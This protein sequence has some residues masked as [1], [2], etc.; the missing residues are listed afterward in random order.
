MIT[1]AIALGLLAGICVAGFQEGAVRKQV[2]YAA[3]PLVA[4]WSLMTF[5]HLTYGFVVLLPVMMLLALND[6]PRSTLR[7]AL[8][9]ILQIG[10]MFD[11][12]GLSRLM[13][14]AGTPLYARVFIHADRVLMLVLFIG[15]IVLAWREPPEPSVSRR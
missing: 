5:Y 11:I 6:T 3:P 1:R 10:M 7:R 8:F 12:P 4:C 15:L 14:F 2:L 13:G 9:W